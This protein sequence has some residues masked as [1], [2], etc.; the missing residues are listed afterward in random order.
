MTD[1][2]QELA[3][4]PAGSFRRL[5]GILQ[6][7]LLVL[8]FLARSVEA[9]EHLAELRVLVLHRRQVIHGRQGSQANIVVTSDRTGV[10]RH[11][12]RRS[13]GIGSQP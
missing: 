11:F 1:I 10:D 4:G 13:G 8:N 7:H 6:F 12:A 5:F 3:L 2:R 9:R